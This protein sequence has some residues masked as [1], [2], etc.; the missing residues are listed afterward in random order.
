M[1]FSK[2][3][4]VDVVEGGKIKKHHKSEFIFM[5]YVRLTRDNTP[6]I[7]ASVMAT[8][9]RPRADPVTIVL[10]DTGKNILFRC[11]GISSPCISVN[12]M[13]RPRH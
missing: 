1:L 6:V 9:H 8:V 12:R 3:F 4:S 10:R 13:L 2:R 7:N 11:L 5:I